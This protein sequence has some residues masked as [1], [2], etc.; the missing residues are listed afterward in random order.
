MIGG[1]GSYKRDVGYKR[2]SVYPDA[3]LETRI[4]LARVDR[5]LY[6]MIVS[7]RCG[8]VSVSSVLVVDIVCRS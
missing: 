6:R 5:S 7:R 1:K 3:C 2:G 4:R 8:K